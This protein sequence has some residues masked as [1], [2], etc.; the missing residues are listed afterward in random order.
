MIFDAFLLFSMH[1]QTSCT[2]PM[3][4]Q[5]SLKLW[6]KLKTASLNLDFTCSYKKGCK[7]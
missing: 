4:E 7:T 6:E 2:L 3:Y 1:C 5:F